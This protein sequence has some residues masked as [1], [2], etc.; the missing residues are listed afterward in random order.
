[1][2]G[3]AG[4]V[5]ALLIGLSM[6][7]GLKV[8]PGHAQRSGQQIRQFEGVGIEQ[9]LGE[10]IPL[11]LVFRNAQGE[12]V[13]LGRYFEKGTPV[14]LEFAYFNCPM[15]CPLM[16][17]G[18]TRTL[19][20][21]AWTPGDEYEVLTVSFNHREGPELARQKKEI[22]VQKLGKADAAEGWHFLT[23]DEATIQ[24]LAQAAGF[25]FKWIPD[26]Q[27]YAHPTA[28]IFL[29]GE[30]KISR[31]LFGMGPPNLTPGKTRKALVEASNGEV[32]SVIDQVVLYCFQYNPD[33]NAYELAFGIMRLG[34]VLTMIFLGGMLFYFWRRE[35]R[36]LDATGT[37]G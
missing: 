10:T 4:Y 3:G 16:L 28:L 9:K 27:Q 21:V 5:V 18:L 26:R 11:D 30:G 7:A 22:Y 35:R 29:S 15:L 14:L 17:Q 8:Q 6:G 31:Y 2:R 19:R 12:Q 36:K 25:N 13:R 34:G 24:A 32:G 23:G 33:S 20:G 1:M 37:V